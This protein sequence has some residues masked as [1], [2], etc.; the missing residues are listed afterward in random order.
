MRVSNEFLLSSVSGADNFMGNVRG[1]AT[2]TAEADA[3]IY[4]LRTRQT[5]AWSEGYTKEF[6][7]PD[8]LMK[9]VHAF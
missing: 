6:S 8:Q 7:H 1:S 3:L 5:E 9:V 2:A 4:T